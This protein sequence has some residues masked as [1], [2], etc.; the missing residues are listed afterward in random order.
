VRADLAAG[1]MVAAQTN[2]MIWSIGT[3]TGSCRW[4]KT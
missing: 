2:S 3:A 4:R 1:D